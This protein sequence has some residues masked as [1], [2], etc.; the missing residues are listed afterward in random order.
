M[1]SELRQKKLKKLFN[2]MDADGSGVLTKA[3][4]ELSFESTVALKGYKPGSSEYQAAFD[5]MV[6]NSWNELAKMDA[7]GDGKVTWDEFLAFY[8]KSSNDPTVSQLITG[9]GEVLFSMVD[10]D[11]NGQISLA[12]FKKMNSVWQ[13]NEAKAEEIFAKLDKKGNG[14]LSKEDFLA[15]C[16]DFFFSD[17]P[18]SPAN[19]LLGAL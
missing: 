7:N 3:D 4:L 11:G 6:T 12:E 5:K 10:A 14:V 15:T 19:S 2:L 18:E 9:G 8:D 17:D 1:A 13:S 16:K